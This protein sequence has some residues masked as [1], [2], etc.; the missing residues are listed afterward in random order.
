[1]YGTRSANQIL[2]GIL[3]WWGEAKVLCED[4]PVSISAGTNYCPTLAQF[5]GWNQLSTKWLVFLPGPHHVRSSWWFLLLTDQPFSSAAALSTLARDLQPS[6]NYSLV[7]HLVPAHKQT[8]T[9]LLMRCLQWSF[10]HKQGS[11]ISKAALSSNGHVLLCLWSK[12]M[13]HTGLQI[14]CKKRFGS[15][16]N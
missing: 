3:R 16:R 14:G 11:L 7:T 10:L 5:P 13:D 12:L 4:T 15:K 6:A 8:E 2:L 9:N 1:M